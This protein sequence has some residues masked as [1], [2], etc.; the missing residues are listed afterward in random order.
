MRTVD[1][2]QVRFSVASLCCIILGFFSPTSTPGVTE[3]FKH[4]SSMAGVCETA[5]T[6]SCPDCWSGREVGRH[7]RTETK[8]NREEQEPPG[9]F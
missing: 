7:K 1:C 2:T 9:N 5:F 6:S 8:E 4:P 3:N